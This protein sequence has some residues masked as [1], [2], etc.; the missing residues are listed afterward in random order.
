[1]C[2]DGCGLLQSALEEYIFRSLRRKGAKMGSDMCLDALLG[3]LLQS[4]LEEYIF[5]SLRRKG[6]MDGF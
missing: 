2:L 6:A 3:G 5:R 4:A 1:M